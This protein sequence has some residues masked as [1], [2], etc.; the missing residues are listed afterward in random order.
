MAHDPGGRRPDPERADHDLP[1]LRDLQV[2]RVRF[3]PPERRNLRSEPTGEHDAIE[4]VVRTE[5]P[6][7]IRALGP[8]LWVGDVPVT[9]SSEVQEG[10][11]RFLALDPEALR[12]G[13]PITLGW[14]GRP[15]DR[16]TEARFFYPEDEPPAG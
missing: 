14:T 16:S 1:A 10:T 4:F 15:P 6:I 11:Y 8:A 12:R 9:E 2:R 13:A 7:P 3:S 5:R